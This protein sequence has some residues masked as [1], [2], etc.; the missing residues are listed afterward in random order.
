[1]KIYKHT[2]PITDPPTPAEMEDK[3]DEADPEEF[4]EWLLKRK[5]EA[6]HDYFNKKWC[7]TPSEINTAVSSLAEESKI[8]VEDY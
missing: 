2:D 8:N 6:T 4:I 3:F 7:L 5:G 1:M